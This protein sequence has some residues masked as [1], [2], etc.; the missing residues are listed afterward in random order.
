MHKLIFF[1]VFLAFAGVTGEKVLAFDGSFE[2]LDLAA[3]M[4]WPDTPLTLEQTIARALANNPEIAARKWDA[5]AAQA[6]MS[7]ATGALLPRLALTGN[8]M[9]HL[10]EQRLIP[11]ASDGSPGLFGRDILM[12][13]LVVSLPLYSGGRLRHQVAATELLHDVA[14]K[15]LARSRDELIFNVTSLYN[16]ILAQQQMIVSLEFSATTLSRHVERIERLIEAGKAARVERLRT[17]VRLADIEQLLV[18]ERN[19]IHLQQRAL[20][21]LLGIVSGHGSSL[22][23]GTLEDSFAETLPEFAAA[24]ALARDARSD[25]RAAVFALQAQERQIDAARA[26]HLPSLSLQGSYGSRWAVGPTTGRGSDQ[27]DVGRIGLVL[28]IPLYS[29]GQV[30]AGLREQRALLAAAQ[31]RLR[32]LEQQIVLEVETALRNITAAAERGRALQQTLDLARESLQIEQQKYDLG[33]GAIIDILDAQAALLQ[34]ESSYYRVL[35]DYHTAW[36]QLTL[37]VGE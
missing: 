12:A 32:T 31:A 25:Y 3:P 34:A 10:D 16:T 29:G 8:Y 36:A 13:D 28:E 18:R 21:G 5:E 19:L 9:H 17:Q 7:T 2:Q 1:L 37:A 14:H 23:T 6:R 4:N 33:K 35:A 11:A 15:R 30:S 22:V 27:A 26:G 24:L 20:A